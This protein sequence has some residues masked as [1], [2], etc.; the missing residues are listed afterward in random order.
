MHATALPGGA[1]DAPDR[2]LQP[3]MGIG[4]HQLD[5]REAALGQAPEECA[6]ESLGLGG[7]D[8]QP[9]DLAAALGIDGHGDYR[10]HGDDAPALALVQVGGIEPEVGPLPLQ[11][12]GQEG[13]DPLVDVL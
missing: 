2:R 5:A 3:L 10:R 7:A 9:D 8:V 12:P 6:P 13:P 1:E 11:W 4:D